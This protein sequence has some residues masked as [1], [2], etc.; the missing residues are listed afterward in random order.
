MQN[1]KH[2][3]LY[4]ILALF[5]VS[6]VNTDNNVKYEPQPIDTLYTEEAAMAIFDHNPERALLIL[7]SAVIVGNLDEGLA[8]M[9]SLSETDGYAKLQEIIKSHYN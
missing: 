3:I 9:R 8:K 7:D 4:I 1:I 6:C 5:A 2:L